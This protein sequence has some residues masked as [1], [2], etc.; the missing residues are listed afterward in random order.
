MDFALPYRGVVAVNTTMGRRKLYITAADRVFFHSELCL[1][2]SEAPLLKAFDEQGV[3]LSRL[4]GRWTL[5]EDSSR[6]M[7]IR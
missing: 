4:T 2:A 1:L 6:F 3:C 7:I 5:L